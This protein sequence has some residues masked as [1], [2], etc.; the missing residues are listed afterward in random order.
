MV[1]AAFK[2]LTGL[3][4]CSHREVNTTNIGSK[5]RRPLDIHVVSVNEKPTVYSPN[6]LSHKGHPSPPQRSSRPPTPYPA[7]YTCCINNTNESA[8]IPTVNTQSQQNALQQFLSCT[9]L[10]Y[11]LPVSTDPRGRGW[12]PFLPHD[13]R[14]KL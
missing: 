7:S 13:G 8:W 6:P 10:D 5:E 12:D 3:T 4:E 1:I 2:G 14:E 11:T 9:E